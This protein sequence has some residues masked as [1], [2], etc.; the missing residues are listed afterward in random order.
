VLTNATKL[1]ILRL[2]NNNR[3]SYG[4][5]EFGFLMVPAVVDIMARAPQKFFL[6]DGITRDLPCCAGREDGQI[7]V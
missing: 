2:M 1:S 7:S 3:K 5:V 4:R 6:Q